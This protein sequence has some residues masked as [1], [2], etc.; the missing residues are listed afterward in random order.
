VLF[1]GPYGRRY[2]AWQ[3]DVSPVRLA[4]VLRPF[5]RA[6]ANAFVVHRF[7]TAAHPALGG[8][9]PAQVRLVDAAPRP[10]TLDGNRLEIL[11][12]LVERY[13]ADH[14]SAGFIDRE[15]S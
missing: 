7:L 15:S 12:T 8:R 5:I 13:K 4:A 2:P 3:F 11:A 10:G 14:F 6:N 9:S 1:P